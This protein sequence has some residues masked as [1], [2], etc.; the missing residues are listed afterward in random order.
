V[1]EISVLMFCNSTN[2]FGTCYILIC[3][4]HILKQTI[5][6]VYCCADKNAS[7]FCMLREDFEKKMNSRLQWS[8]THLVHSDTPLFTYWLGFQRS[9][10]S[11]IFC[12]LEMSKCSTV[13]VCVCVCVFYTVC[14]Q[15]Y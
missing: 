14:I 3:Y 6:N 7:E 5:L 15:M 4:A 13:C 1:V 10:A 9:L 8:C 11:Q 12:R 2:L